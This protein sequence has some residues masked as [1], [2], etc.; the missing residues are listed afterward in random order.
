MKK[1][2]KQIIRIAGD[3]N[4]PTSYQVTSEL[5]AVL[6][7]CGTK[8]SAQGVIRALEADCDYL[9]LPNETKHKWVKK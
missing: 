6:A 9:K 5:G 2:K 7:Y 8:R 3:Y 1:L 4:H